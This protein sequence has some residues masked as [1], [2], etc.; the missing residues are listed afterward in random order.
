MAQCPKCGYHLKITDIS[1]FC[2]K[3]KVNMRFFGFEENFYKEAKLAELTQAGI[4]VKIRRLKAAFIGSKLAIARLIVML[5]PAAALLIP[6]GGYSIDLPFRSS[7]A[8]FGI[9]GAVSLFTGPDLGF[10]G[11][12]TSSP[13][14][15]AQF[16]SLQKTIFVFLS[17]AVFAV[18]V[19]LLS[20][21][22]FISI[23]NMQKITFFAA[24]LGAL[25]CV[26]AMIVISSFA[27]NSSGDGVV[28]GKTGFGLIVVLLMFLV[29]AAV[30]LI[31]WKKGIAVE[32]DEGMLERVEIFKKV[33]AGE[34]SMD[35]LPQPVV[36]TEATRAIDAEIEKEEAAYRERHTK[37]AEEE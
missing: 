2:P 33:K 10:I 8:D 25:D 34:I 12:M 4:H 3:C 37:K 18:I 5:L 35:D 36:E 6:A 30:N 19:L 32:Y 23:K 20:I 14:T 15:G 1:Q 24:I 16:A 29:V 31:L 21:L 27:K 22:C 11:S 13:T 9:M 17:V 26:A 28:T 7:S